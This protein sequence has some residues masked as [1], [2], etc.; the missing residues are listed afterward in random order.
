[1]DGI[2]TAATPM[3]SPRTLWHWVQ[4]LVW[5]AGMF[6]WVALIVR[7][8]L[9]LHLL[10]NV[11]I[12]IAPALLVLAPGVWRNVCPLG[13]MSLAPHHF[14][15]SQ[16]KNLSQAW[17]GRLYL[18]ALILLLVVVPLRK[19]ILDTNGPLLAAILAVV[20]L[21]AIGLGFAFNWK[22]SWCS[23]ASARCTLWNCSTVR[24]R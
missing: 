2:T 22:S 7:P 5:A 3:S 24:G 23:T 6:I 4:G 13:S 9:G 14:G 17:R 11:L 10:W 21:L 15:L 20:G 8:A 1:M 19:V 18:V 12:P 16:G